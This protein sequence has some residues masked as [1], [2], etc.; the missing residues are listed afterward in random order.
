MSRKFLVI[1]PKT[2]QSCTAASNAISRD[3]HS[4]IETVHIFVRTEAPGSPNLFLEQK[5]P[6]SIQAHWVLPPN[7]VEGHGFTVSFS[8]GSSGAVHISNRIYAN[9]HIF[10]GLRNGANYT[11]TIVVTPAD[12]DELPS[13]PTFSNLRPLGRIYLIMHEGWIFCYDMVSISNASEGAASVWL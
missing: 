1:L 7:L 13:S 4:K 5:S 2:V 10:T 6:T 12:P 8:G 11:M 9:N 3:S